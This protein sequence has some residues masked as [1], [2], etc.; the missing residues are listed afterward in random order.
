MNDDNVCVICEGKKIYF[1]HPCTFCNGTGEWNEP[2]ENYLRDHICQCI[3]WG[4]K[5]CPV[6]GKKCHHD[7]SQTPKQRI[8]PGYGGLTST[9]SVTS[10]TE[11]TD[12]T[13]DN[14]PIQEFITV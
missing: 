13:P 9:I 6:C 3:V 10:V 5:F 11:F 7:S 14:E 12:T 1:G 4:R 2:G 8:V